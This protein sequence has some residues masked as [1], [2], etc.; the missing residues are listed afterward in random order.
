MAGSAEMAQAQILGEAALKAMRANEVPPTPQNFTVW[1]TYLA[2][3]VPELKT[4]LDTL[5]AA[6]HVFTTEINTELFGRFFDGSGQ[7]SL[8]QDT[9]GRLNHIVDQVRKH[10]DSAAG[11]ANA[12]GRTLD[13]FSLAIGDGGKPDVRGLIADLVSETQQVALRNRSL[14]ERLNRASGEV[15]ELKQNLQHVQ[16]E[17]LTDGLTGIPNRKSFEAR[18]RDAAH[19]ALENAEHLSLLIAD[20][21]LFKRFN[22]TYG[23]QIGD[24]V[25]KLV[26][27]TLT[28]SVKG[29]D[30][31]ARYGGEEFAI[32][33][34]QTRLN[35]ARIVAEQIRNGLM[36]R[37]LVS[38]DT[39]DDYGTVTLS[40]G[41][42][43][44][45]PGEDLAALV[46]RADAALYHAK[47]LGRNRVATEE[48]LPDEVVAT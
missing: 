36:R 4:A 12:F 13:D 23:H 10:L 34:P 22:D 24:Q 1:Y 28:D 21:D 48:M 11:D 5:I 19:D 27:K 37:K 47:R 20:I 43:Q 30:T 46:Q 3:T 45:R 14:E 41:A 38:R 18:L 7:L 9:G 42:A 26:A 44:Y 8:L 33:L 39:R 2:G 35:D 25:L 15:T 17:A 31:P 29:R 32:I 40:F 6:H 16:R